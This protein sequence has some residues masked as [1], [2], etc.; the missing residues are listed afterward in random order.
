MSIIVIEGPDGVGKTSV[1]HEIVELVGPGAVYMRCPGSTKLGELLRGPLKDPSFKITPFVMTML[2][3]A[4]DEDAHQKAIELSSSGKTVVMDRCAISNIVY[5]QA[6]EQWDE[7]GCV[8]WLLMGEEMRIAP[9]GSHIVFLD[10]SD[11]VRAQRLKDSGRFEPDRFDGLGKVVAELYTEMYK[12]LLAR[13]GDRVNRVNTDL[14]SAEMVA[15]LIANA[16]KLA[17]TDH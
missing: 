5:R 2:F 7:V 9:M 8:E 15:T 17:S 3:V 10:A 11:K 16:H 12:R 14:A 13:L 6:Q 4:V 1:C